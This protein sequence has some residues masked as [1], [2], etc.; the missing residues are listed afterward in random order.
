MPMSMIPILWYVSASYFAEKYVL[1]ECF[2]LNRLNG[3]PYFF[4]TR[5]LSG[6]VQ[7]HPFMTNLAHRNAMQLMFFRPNIPISDSL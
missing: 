4:I 1:F 6:R 5:P 2:L 7:S 3:T